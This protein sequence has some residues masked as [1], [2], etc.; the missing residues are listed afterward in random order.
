MCERCVPVLS[1]RRALALAGAAAT[2]VVLGD[3]VR[4]AHAQAW[5]TGYGVDIQ[6]RA[7]WAG[8]TRPF[9]GEAQPED[10]RFLLVHHTAGS[11]SGDPIELMRDVYRFHTSAEKG[12]PDVAY[13]FFIEP[14]GQVYEARA[15]SLDRAVEA[16]ASGGNQGFAQLVCLLGDFTSENPTPA[17]L[18]ALNATLAW[19]ADRYG[20][21]TSPGATTEFVSRGSN[22]WD[23]GAVVMAKVISGHRDMSATACPGDT[24]Y[25]YLV[26][27]VQAEVELLRN[28]APSIEPPDT[29]PPVT[30]RPVTERPLET[31]AT[32]TDPDPGPGPDSTSSTSAPSPSTVPPSIVPPTVARGAEDSAPG[33]SGLD[34]VPGA[35]P[36][37]STESSNAA[38]WTLGAGATALVGAV[39]V[40]A[41]IR[42][43]RS[44]SESAVEPLQ[45]E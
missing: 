18:T 34:T 37:A 41:G 36:T 40:A 22:R 33:A 27:N 12:W 15:G 30:E 19:L 32:N 25:P 16:S 3:P 14:G 9:V 31:V 29:E 4:S 39:A 8:D 23:E 13:N 44:D 21:D 2:A 43:H 26:E 20:L 10:V 42:A 35:G 11:S 7:V 38:A 24:F 5:Q 28:G 45:G 17:A 6:P 1:R